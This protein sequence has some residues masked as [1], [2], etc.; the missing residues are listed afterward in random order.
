[1]IGSLPLP[2]SFVASGP[3]FEAFVE[4]TLHASLF[5]QGTDRRT[6]TA[7]RPIQIRPLVPNLLTTISL[8]RHN[9]EHTFTSFRL[10]PG[11]EHGFGHL[12]FR[13]HFSQFLKTPRVP[14]LS[15]YLQADI[16][17][18]I[19]L[20]YPWRLPFR[21][22]IVASRRHTSEILHHVRYTVW[23]KKFELLLIASTQVKA[24]GSHDRPNSGTVTHAVCVSPTRSLIRNPGFARLGIESRSRGSDTKDKEDD[25]STG[26]PGSMS[27]DS[28]CRREK[29]GELAD[30]GFRYSQP[31]IEVKG[32]S[33]SSAR[34]EKKLLPGYDNEK[35]C[36]EEQPIF[37]GD[38]ERKNMWDGEEDRCK[39]PVEDQPMPSEGMG[40]GFP[41]SCPEKD[42]IPDNEKETVDQPVDKKGTI[43]QPDNEAETPSSS[44][45]FR[46]SAAGQ[47]NRQL[48]FFRVK[49][50]DEESETVD[51]GSLLELWVE[52][53]SMDRGGETIN[54]DF[55]TWSIRRTHQWKWRMTVQVSG[56]GQSS[57][58]G[59]TQDVTVVGP[60]E[61]LSAQGRK[62]VDS[63]DS[64]ITNVIPTTKHKA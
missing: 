37:S 15:L 59:G 50:D 14:R 5:L 21:V 57:T 32:Q 40:N 61:R 41:S 55:T 63:R 36:S 28:S 11:M 30:R 62:V 22:R 7:L 60:C 53:C 39:I 26:F 44:E 48:P 2:P 6:C 25:D 1:M 8:A 51:L 35:V 18:V 54:P 9:D 34:L 43:D 17:T 56:S 24:P 4:Y 23:I 42:T 49:W 45:L 13:D 12:N 64:Q 10:S 16:P 52:S 19:Q 38:K 33:D 20:G 58:F 31:S 47:P 29:Y 46:W 27:K 3:T